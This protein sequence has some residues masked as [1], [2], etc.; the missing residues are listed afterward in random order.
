MSISVEQVLTL[1][2]EQNGFFQTL[3]GVKNYV[4]HDDTTAKE[5]IDR[6][7]HEIAPKDRKEIVQ[8]LTAMIDN[9][10]NQGQARQEHVVSTLLMLS[11]LSKKKRK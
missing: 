1:S 10:I 6:L 5:Q 3:N 2:L 7:A 8:H 9:R 11:N 4:F